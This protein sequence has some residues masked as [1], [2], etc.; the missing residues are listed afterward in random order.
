M[1]ISILL[2][3]V[4]FIVPNLSSNLW[5]KGDCS[6]VVSGEYIFL[7][8]LPLSW[9]KSTS[10]VLLSSYSS[11]HPFTYVSWGERL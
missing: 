4:L 7:G 2:S 5:W 6:W 3:E 9:D 10:S 8:R 11:H 1:K